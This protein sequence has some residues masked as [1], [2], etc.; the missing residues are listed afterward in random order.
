MRGIQL[1]H[2]INV[3]KIVA[4]RRL[5]ES[6]RVY[7]GCESRDVRYGIACEHEIQKPVFFCGLFHRMCASSYQLFS[8]WLIEVVDFISQSMSINQLPT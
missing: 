2:R 1:I 7:V 3:A 5:T 4:L 6:V 8:V